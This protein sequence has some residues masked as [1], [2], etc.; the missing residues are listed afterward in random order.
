[1][2]NPARGSTP[3]RPLAKPVLE[4]MKETGESPRWLE[5]VGFAAI[6]A[7]R[8]GCFGRSLRGA[9][10]G[11]SAGAQW[12]TPRRPAIAAK[13]YDLA[14]GFRTSSRNAH[15]EARDSATT[16]RGDA[17]NVRGAK[18]ADAVLE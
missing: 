1:M 6:E 9:A 14:H 4:E 10:G 12:E 16:S 15:L 5:R 7:A 2:R 17:G 8:W 18:L 11:G 13:S 3:S